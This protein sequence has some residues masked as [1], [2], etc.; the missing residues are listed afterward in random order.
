M[1]RH[2]L[3]AVHAH[4]DDEVV[5]T[6]GILA[7]YADEGSTR[8]WSHAPTRS[9]ATGLQESSQAKRAMTPKP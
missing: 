2:R 5:S 4:P 3:M 8:S 6:G 9:K 7:P 1:T